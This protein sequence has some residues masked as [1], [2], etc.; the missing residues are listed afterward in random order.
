MRRNAITSTDKKTRG[1]TKKRK[2]NKGKKSLK[3]YLKRL[4]VGRIFTQVNCFMNK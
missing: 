2:N 1:N 3:S 4:L